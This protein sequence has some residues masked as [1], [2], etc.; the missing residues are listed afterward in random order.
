[1]L[2]A[3]RYADWEL[4]AAASLGNTLGA[5]INWWLGRF[6]AHFENRRW[7]PVKKAALTRAEQWFKRWG[8]WSLLLSWMPIVGDPLTMM[9]G[10]LRMPILPFLSIVAIAKAGRYLAIMA[11]L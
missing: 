7:F 6:I 1:M 3:D 8:K 5:V 10:I 11:A 2:M 4:L 9:A